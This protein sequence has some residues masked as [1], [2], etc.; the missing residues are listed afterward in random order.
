MR[1]T[2]PLFFILIA[3][4]GSVEAGAAFQRPAGMADANEPLIVAGYRALFT[5]SAHFVAGRPL[6]DILRTELVDVSEHALP[7]LVIDAGEF[8]VS[9][10]DGHGNEQ[11]AVYRR[12]MGCTLLPPHWNAGDA[13][14][15]PY[16]ELPPA[17]DMSDTP[18]PRG[19]RVR[20]RSNGLHRQAGRLEP[21]LDSA[22]DGNSF[23]S[24]SVTAAVLVVRDGLLLAERYRDGFGVH[25]GYRTWSTAKS[26]SAAVI[27]IAAGEGIFNLD[28]PVAIP[29]WQ[30]GQDPRAE[31]TYKHLLWMSSGLFSGGSNTNAIYFGGQDV[32]SAA[33]TTRLEAPAGSR[34]QYA[35]NDTL[36]LLRSLRYSL[37]DDAAYL[38]YPYSKLLHRIGMYHTRMEIDHKGNFVGS[39]QVYTTARDL[40]RFGVLLANDGVWFGT[41]ILPE[42]WVE[43]S[44]TPAPTR[45]PEAGVNG[46]GAQFWLLD[47]HE[48]VPQGTFSTAGNK[49]QWVTVVPAE[50]LVIVRTGVDPQGV[51]WQQHRFVAE[52]VKAL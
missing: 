3:S 52:V 12:G 39:S 29:E 6:E 2:V 7:L 30:H 15:L 28:E 27:G 40:A 5:C 14:R 23:A 32:V 8:T 22:F 31:I 38:R 47:Q 50:K 25:A 16:V 46:Y 4:A 42:G 9:A 35:N 11:V 33:T 37:R 18:F 10:R 17:P 49:G 43:F 26:I 24:G 19:D 44:A 13:A 45:P 51:R 1:R 36:L 20:L 21:V 34:W 41:R 48:G